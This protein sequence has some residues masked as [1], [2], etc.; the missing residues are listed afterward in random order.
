MYK[1]AT[2]VTSRC[3]DLAACLALRLAGTQFPL[4]PPYNTH[5]RQCDNTTSLVGSDVGNFNGSGDAVMIACIP[6]GETALSG[7]NFGGSNDKSG[8]TEAGGVHR[9]V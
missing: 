2:I 6:D 9:C 5:L 7:L 3:I 1:F 8:T 4:L